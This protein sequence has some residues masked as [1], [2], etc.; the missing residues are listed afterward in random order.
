[1][2]LSL[3]IDSA[4]TNT[5]FI[6]ITLSASYAIP[7]NTLPLCTLRSESNFGA[8]YLVSCTYT[9]GT[10][11]Y[12]LSALEAIP[13]GRYII[14]ISNLHYNMANEG[15]AFAANLNR[16]SVLVQVNSAT[17]TIVSID[18]T[19]LTPYTGNFIQ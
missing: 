16:V 19:Y 13:T 17:G 4:L 9:A 3:N 2:R 1:L 12:L 7:A 18:K 14:E 6:Q 15:V 10:G 8:P 5:G 11:V